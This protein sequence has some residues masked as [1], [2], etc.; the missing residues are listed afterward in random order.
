MM[1]VTYRYVAGLS[2]LSG[3]PPEQL[4]RETRSDSG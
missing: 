4:T 1:D 2:K 3:V